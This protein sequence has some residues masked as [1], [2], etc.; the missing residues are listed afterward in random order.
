[1]IM[2]DSS[3][4]ARLIL[5]TYCALDDTALTRPSRA[6]RTLAANLVARGVTFDLAHAAFILACARRRVTTCVGALQPIR[7]LAYFL[8]IIEELL[9]TPPDP[10]YVRYLA[11]RLHGPKNS[12]SK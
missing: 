8:P 10:D 3:A 5:A 6:D 9:D 7:S 2:S 12:G 11:S 4:N 1:M